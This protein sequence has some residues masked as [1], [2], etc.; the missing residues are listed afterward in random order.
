MLKVDLLVAAPPSQLPFQARAVPELGAHATTLPFLSFLLPDSLMA[1][2]VG[3]SLIVPVRVPDPA[4]YCLHKIV[5]A[6]LRPANEAAKMLKDLQQA[7]AL[8]VI[9][10][11]DDPQ[12]LEEIAKEMDASFR[13]HVAAKL[14]VVLK[15]MH[16]WPEAADLLQ[17]IV[18]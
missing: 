6:D 16:E 11:E 5:V 1:V 4:R 12:R 18:G 7:A 9:L 3:R 15:S 10:S 2:T 17:R 14:P 8:A 13:R